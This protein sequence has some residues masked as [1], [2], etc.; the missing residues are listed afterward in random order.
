VILS[1]AS[2]TVQPATGILFNSLPYFALSPGTCLGLTII[3]VNAGGGPVTM[4]T[5][6]KLID[7][8]ITT[9]GSGGFAFYS[10]SGCTTPTSSVTRTGDFV[11]PV[12]YA[13]DPGEGSSHFTAQSHN[14]SS[15]ITPDNTLN[16]VYPAGGD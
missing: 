16:F 12:V 3:G 15:L 6:E 10:D 9:N 7:L 4:K 2:Y 5:T 14:N 1:A 11:G 13:K 8:S